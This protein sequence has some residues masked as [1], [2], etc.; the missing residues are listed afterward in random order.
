MKVT[1]SLKMLTILSICP[2]LTV[3]LF[4]LYSTV[5]LSP[6]ITHCATVDIQLQTTLQTP[7]TRLQILTPFNSSQNTIEIPLIIRNI[8][9][10]F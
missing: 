2:M 5:I 8:I 6:G 10:I 1:L 9:I 7:C 4:V 3:F